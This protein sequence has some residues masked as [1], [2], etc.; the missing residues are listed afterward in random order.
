MPH[1]TSEDGGSFQRP[2]GRVTDIFR[3]GALIEYT[4]KFCAAFGYDTSAP[5]ASHFVSLNSGDLM[6]Y[7]DSV[8]IDNYQF[9]EVS[10]MSKG[11]ACTTLFHRFLLGDKIIKV[12]DETS[13]MHLDFHYA[14]TSAADK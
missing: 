1:S 7:L 8:V 5:V 14:A 3:S 13:N 12:V 11:F 6:L 9:L 2:P 10:P 4:G